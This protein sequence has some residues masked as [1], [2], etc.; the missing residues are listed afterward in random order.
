MGCASEEAA[1]VW[2]ISAAKRL[3][4]GE[5]DKPQMEAEKREW[6][7]TNGLAVRKKPSGQ[8]KILKR[9]AASTSVPTPKK[10]KGTSDDD[11]GEPEEHAAD[12]EGDEDGSTKEEKLDVNE[13]EEEEDEANDE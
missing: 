2:M 13:D 1:K 12:E 3:L 8:T 9:P 10:P 4:S 6:L 7:S 5:I 11:I